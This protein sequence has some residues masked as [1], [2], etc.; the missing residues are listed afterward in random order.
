M[1]SKIKVISESGEEILVDFDASDSILKVKHRVFIENDI[2][3]Y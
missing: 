1:E 2:P 3:V